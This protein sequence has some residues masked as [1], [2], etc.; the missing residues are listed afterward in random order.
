MSGKVTT[1]NLSINTTVNQPF[2]LF[3]ALSAFT[4]SQTLGGTDFTI[5]NY[6][7]IQVYT[8]AN[9]GISHTST[10]GPTISY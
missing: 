1:G 4:V 7:F 10:A 5:G 3:F 8:I 9:T 6:R 2:S